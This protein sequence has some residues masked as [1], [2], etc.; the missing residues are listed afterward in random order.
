MIEPA[1]FESFSAAPTFSILDESSLL[2]LSLSLVVPRVHP[3]KEVAFIGRVVAVGATDNGRDSHTPALS[4]GGDNSIGLWDGTEQARAREAAVK[5]GE[6]KMVQKKML[7][8]VKWITM[9]NE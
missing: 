2:P 8:H 6:G 1:V 7:I 4:Y 5:W 3:K 9:P